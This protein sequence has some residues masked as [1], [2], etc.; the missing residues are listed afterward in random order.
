MR[1][2]RGKLAGWAKELIDECYSSREARCDLYRLW[3]AYYY[4]GT[5]DGVQAV[6]NR[7]YSHIDRL[8][9]F[10]FSPSDVRY[11]FEGD[12]ALEGPDIEMLA[13]GARYLN[14][15]FHR[16]NVD[17]VFA[18]GVT[19]ALVKGA[20]LEKTLWGHD[21]LEPW[22]VQPESFGVLRED[23]G[24]LDRQDAFVETTY[25]T[26]AAFRRTL[27]SGWGPH[28]SNPHPERS[29]IIR[30]VEK[31]LKSRADENAPQDDYLM[32]IV[33]GGTGPVSTT[34]SGGKAMVNFSSV[35]KP[36]L[37]PDVARR[38]VK[39]QELWVV[40]DE[41]QDY[42]TIRM[43]EDIVI[44][45]DV[46][47]RNLSGVKE[48]HP[49]TKICPNE[50]DSYFWGMS[51]IAQVYKLQD[52]LNTQIMNLQKVT[53]LKADPPRALIGFTGVT[54][55][56]YNA[57]RRPGGKITEDNP[58]AKIENLSPEVPQEIL[59]ER[60]NAT[61]QYFDD[62]AGFT[63]VLM[64]QGEQGVRSQAQAQTL[65]RNGS[66][67]MRDRALLVE[68][69]AVEL[70]EF[71]YKLSA[72]KE[73]EAQQTEKKAPFLL[74]QVLEKNYRATIDSHTASPAFQED[75]RNL[76]V[77]LKKLGVIDD[78]DTILLTHPPHEDMLVLKAKQKAE[79]QAK[80]VAQHPELLLG[81]GGKKGK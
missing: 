46:K 54:E 37:S 35:P 61:V 10:L 59:I 12:L 56:K 75:T 62:V 77:A 80:L 74:A 63:P 31:S 57:L 73:A 3:T 64:G 76:A 41:R 60:I 43:V 69:Q 26:P 58:N 19:W 78:E 70:G 47:R 24:D 11:A 68:R 65:S 33:V 53:A 48:E 9:S 17:Q 50:V 20:C 13:A 32:Q 4:G 28:Q 55:E 38:L 16:T 51:E 71:A 2:P 8:G 25:M 7:T 21:G 18:S 27:S 52:L 29:A 22:L 81:K 45:G 66:P 72:S 39:H 5:S 79:M 23:I 42:T 1:L 36:M 15:E 6:Y 40:D 67:R 49:Y 44:E 34:Q 30:E 14:R